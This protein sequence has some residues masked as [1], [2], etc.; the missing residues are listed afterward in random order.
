MCST[1]FAAYTYIVCA[2][3]KIAGL[4]ADFHVASRAE[5]SRYSANGQSLES[6]R[7]NIELFG[8]SIVHL[9]D[10]KMT[11]IQGRKLAA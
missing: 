8:H 9:C 5:V 2:G 4:A 1:K 6:L 7:R 11:Y 3:A 10:W